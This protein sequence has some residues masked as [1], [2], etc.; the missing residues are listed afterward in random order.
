MNKTNI[1]TTHNQKHKTEQAYVE[2]H[3]TSKQIDAYKQRKRHMS[4]LAKTGLCL[5]V[6]LFVCFYYSY[7]YY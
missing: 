7:D 5:F 3:E 4:M 2:N 1:I 6:C